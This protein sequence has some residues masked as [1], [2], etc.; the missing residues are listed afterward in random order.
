MRPHCPPLIRVLGGLVCL[1]LWLTAGCGLPLPP[2]SPPAPA[3]TLPASTA[4]SPAP[5]A[6]PVP[7]LQAPADTPAPPSPLAPP[8]TATPVSM[9]ALAPQYTLEADL[10][11]HLHTA[12]VTATVALNLPQTRELAFTVDALRHPGVFNLFS[13][14]VNGLPATPFTSGVYLHVPVPAEAAPGARVTATLIYQLVLPALGTNPADV[15]GPL[16]W[17]PRQTNLGDWYPVLA[18]FTPEQGWNLPSPASVGEYHSAE[19]A[20][21]T[22]TLRVVRGMATPRVFGSGQPVACPAYCFS[23]QGARFAAYTLS[24]QMRSQS[25]TTSAGV[26]VTAAYFI[27]HDAP[28]QAALEVARGALEGFSALYGAYPY[29]TFTLVEGDFYDGMEYSGLSFVGES[30][31]TA[32]DQT[33]NNLLTAIAAHETAHQWWHSLVGND[34]ALEPWLDEALCTYSELLYLEAAHPEVVRNWWNWRIQAHAP[35]GAVNSPIYAFDSFR[36]YVNAVYLRGAQMLHFMRQALGEEA[37]QSFLR[38]YAQANAGR[39]A[40]GADFWRAYQAAGG[41]AEEVQALYFAKP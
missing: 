39:T 13:V 34:P 18:V 5:S 10:D 35:G 26:T 24:D 21:Y 30:Y 4:T 25:I 40:H 20:D 3:T 9:P 6:S 12:L 8:P 17:T 41:D 7:T 38:A 2:V 15:P 16:G 23:M 31:Y 14:T 33:A 37:F 32:F 36:P 29:A 27:G 19:P 1:A 11:A 22:V 28:G